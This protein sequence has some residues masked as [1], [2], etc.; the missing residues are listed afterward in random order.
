[1][2]SF[3]R[4]T[5]Q[6]AGV[7]HVVVDLG[8]VGVLVHC[9]PT[10]AASVRVGDH[11]E[12][13]T[14]M[15]VREDAWTLYGF[16]DADERSVFEQVQTVTGIGPRIALALLGTLTPD[17]LRRALASGDEAALTAVPGIGRKGAQRLILELADRLGA[18]LAASV[19][20]PAS[21][22]ASGWRASVVAGLTS[23]GWS[24]REAEAAVASLDPGLIAEAD[25]RGSD[26]DVAALLK[27][28]L[29]GLDRS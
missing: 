20:T 19:R 25:A 16:L 9:T 6:R 12:L 24:A 26:A 21:A 13:L 5:V 29:R 7:D 27:A 11:V 22:A 2:I 18:P 4:G 8:A 28:A 10:S 14:T 3:V 1:M 17:E 23:L 15:V